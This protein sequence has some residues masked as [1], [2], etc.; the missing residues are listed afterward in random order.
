MRLKRIY[1]KNLIALEIAHTAR[2]MVN[3]Y[4]SK[5]SNGKEVS[6]AQYI[7]EIICE[8]RAKQNGE[9]LHYRFWVNKKWSNFYKNQIASANVLVKKYKTNAIIR[10]LNDPEAYKIYSLR[11][12]FLIP[13]IEKHQSII[14]SENQTLNK[15]YTRKTD[16]V[17]FGKK[18]SKKNIISKL[19]DLDDN[20]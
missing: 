20:E 1:K 17:K 6:P 4:I 5:Y 9:D 8:K 10:A 15:E 7:T 16:N 14:E 13:I 11:A 2:A 12:P 19:R 18:I 3:K